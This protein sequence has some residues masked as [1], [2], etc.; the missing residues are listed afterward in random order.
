MDVEGDRHA[1]I[2]ID[3]GKESNN[4]QFIITIEKGCFFVIE[5]KGVDSDMNRLMK[6]TDHR[7]LSRLE[8]T[9]LYLNK[10]LQK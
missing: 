1:L 3:L 6:S 9:Q 4:E 7:K 5:L 8:E 10:L 2:Q